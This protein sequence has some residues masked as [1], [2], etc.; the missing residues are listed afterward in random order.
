MRYFGLSQLR[1]EDDEEEV[2]YLQ[3]LWQSSQL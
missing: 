2:H 1:Q 3:S